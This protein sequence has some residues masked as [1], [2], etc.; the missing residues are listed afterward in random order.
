MAAGRDIETA[1]S[2]A[3]A[4]HTMLRQNILSKNNTVSRFNIF[5]VIIVGFVNINYLKK[6]NVIP[7]KAGIQPSTI[8]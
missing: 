2:A 8:N 1:G 6:H 7:A 4:L 3:Y 5:K